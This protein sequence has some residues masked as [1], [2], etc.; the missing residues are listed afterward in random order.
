MKAANMMTD[1]ETLQKKLME[2]RDLE[3]ELRAA[4]DED[5]GTTSA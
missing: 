2:L 4:L 5:S 1:G 3:R